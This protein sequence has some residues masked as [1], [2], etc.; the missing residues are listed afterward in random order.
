MSGL[1][2]SRVATYEIVDEDGMM[3]GATLNDGGA[4][5]QIR[6]ADSDGGEVHFRQDEVAA[7]L[8]LLERFA[9]TG[10][11]DEPP[12][13]AVWIR[14]EDRL[15]PEGVSLIAKAGRTG[16]RVGMFIAGRWIEHYGDAFDCPDLWM[17]IPP[18]PPEA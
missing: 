15:P 14:T 16:D 8:P 1:K 9:V 18:T 7:M 17:L 10:G 13:V 3:T 12:A 2:M 6:V 4:A 11:L 5:G